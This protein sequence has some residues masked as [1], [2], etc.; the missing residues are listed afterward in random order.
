MVDLY[1]LFMKPVVPG[2]EYGQSFFGVFQEVGKVT[3]GFS[4]RA[5][6]DT[7]FSL[8]LQKTVWNR[9]QITG[10]SP[11]FCTLDAPMPSAFLDY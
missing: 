2:R 5:S 4:L 8:P 1:P 10:M 3:I 7:F 6:F 11:V 9:A